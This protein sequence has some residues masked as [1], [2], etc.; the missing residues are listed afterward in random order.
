MDEEGDRKLDAMANMADRP[1]SLQDYLAEQLGEMELD[2]DQRRLAKHICTLHRPH[3][4]PR[5]APRDR[6]ARTTDKDTF[7]TDHARRDRR[8]VLRP[9][10]MH[11]R[12]R[13]GHARPRRPEARTAR[14]RRPRPE[15]VP[16]PPGRR[17]RR[18]ARRRRCA[19]S[20]RDHLEDVAYNRIPVIQKATRFDIPTIQDAIEALAPP[21]PEAGAEVRRHRARSTSCPT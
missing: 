7:R 4:L 18:P 15:G 11:R 9:S 21:R 5:H 14:R 16:A 19:C 20:I 10:S 3:R 6:P 13:R 12:G 1:Q 8:P 17:P 2:E